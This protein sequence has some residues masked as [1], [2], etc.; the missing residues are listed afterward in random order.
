MTTITR[1]VA[2]LIL[3]LTFSGI[4]AQEKTNDSID[5][6]AK[7]YK[8]LK[9]SKLE[10]SKKKVEEEEREYLKAEVESINQRLSKGQITVAEA[11]TLKKEAA[12]I[13]AANI[14]DRIDQKKSIYGW[15]CY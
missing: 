1:Y 6:A 10:D 4:S 2:V 14:E 13:R 12:R 8:E 7:A 11:E 15:N 3:C 9:I 5:S